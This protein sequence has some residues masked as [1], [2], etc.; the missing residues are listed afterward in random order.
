MAFNPIVTGGEKTG[1]SVFGKDITERK[2]ALDG[3]REREARL[4]EAEQLAVAGSSSWDVDTDTTTWS[5]G[6]FSI[7]GWDPNTPPPSRAERAKLYTEESWTRLDAAVKHALASGEPYD[8]ELQIIRPDGSL[9]WTRARGRAV[10]DGLGHVHRLIGTLQ[11][12]TEQK[13]AEAKLRES[14]ERYRATFEQAAI[15]IV[16]TSLEGSIIRCNARFAGIVGYPIEEVPGLTIQQITAP[17]DLAANA[18]MLQKLFDGSGRHASWEKRYLRKD[19]AFTWVRLTSSIQR[20]SEGK[21]LHLVT[22]VVDIN[23][24]KSAEERLIAAQETLRASELRY[25]TLFQVSIDPFCVIRLSDGVF[26]DVNL[27][28][29]NVMGYISDEVIGHSTVELGIWADLADRQRIMDA[30]RKDSGIR[31]LE[32]R[33]RKKNGEILPV[34]LSASTIEIDGVPCLL[35]VLRDLTEAKAAAQKLET[36]QEAIRNNEER[37]RTVFHTNLY[38]IAISRLDDG[39]Y[40][41]VNQAFLKMVGFEREEVIGQGSAELGFWTDAKIREETVEVLRRD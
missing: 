12:T 25:R 18:Q 39:R 4:R 15:G 19:G 23:L 6:L 11:D 7:T 5:E 27:A 20:D 38:G 35:G 36:A 31:D 1:I 26:L 41:D 10:R 9:C 8:L 30:F 33:F 22:F 34:M 13:L 29:L 14:E 16:H 24:R 28:F 3:L 37:Y 32:S 17:E 40:I 21:A 2:Q